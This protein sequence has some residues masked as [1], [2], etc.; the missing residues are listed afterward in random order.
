MFEVAYRKRLS[1][2]LPA[3]RERGWVTPEGSAAILASLEGRRSTFGMAA[4]VGLVGALLLG[5]GVLAFV[6]AN[7]EG[8]PRQVHFLLLLAGMAIAYALADGLAARG[9]KAFADAALLVAGL[10]FAAAI[11]LIGQSYHLSGDFSGALLLFEIGCLG[12]ALL[13]GSITLTV[14]ALAGAGY[15]TWFASVDGGFFP[16]WPSL[17]AIIVGGAVATYPRHA[18]R[19]RRRRARPDVLGGRHRRGIRRPLRHAVRGHVRARRH[20]C[21][22]SLGARDGAR[23]PGGLAADCRARLPDDLARG[24]PRS[25]SSSASC[26]PPASGATG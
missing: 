3:W 9:L 18:L 25:S 17:V 5:L 11:A 15:W 21:A 26:R 6:A 2:D 7:W 4:I 13:T 22:P 1:A 12:A 8:L 16:H 23:Q 20:A 14:L 10:I 24:S 19:P